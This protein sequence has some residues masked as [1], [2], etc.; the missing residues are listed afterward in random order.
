VQQYQVESARCRRGHQHGSHLAKGSC[1]RHLEER[2]RAKWL[3]QDFEETV[4]VVTRPNRGLHWLALGAALKVLDA[5]P[6]HRLTPTVVNNGWDCTDMNK[7]F[8]EFSA[9]SVRRLCHGPL[10]RIAFEV[11]SDAKAMRHIAQ[12]GIARV[13]DDP[14]LPLSNAVLWTSAGDVLHLRS[15]EDEGG[16]LEVLEGSRRAA[17]QRLR[18]WCHGAPTWLEGEPFANRLCLEIDLH[19]G[20]VSLSISDWGL[21]PIILSV[22]ALQIQD[23]D[24]PWYPIVSLTGEGQEAR[25]VD[26]QVRSLM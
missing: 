19:A 24:Y 11:R 7:A 21:D 4:P 22:P 12:V 2:R 6:A 9:V 15:D 25:L 3:I 8:P 16:Q 10:N 18:D 23:A 1:V 13:P 26:F 5:L 20:R 17:S 14:S